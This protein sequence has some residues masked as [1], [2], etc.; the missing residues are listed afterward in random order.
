MNVRVSSFFYGLFVSLSLIILAF[1]S[2]IAVIWPTINYYD[3]LFAVIVFI[4]F[5]V[6]NILR[7]QVDDVIIIIGLLVLILLGVVGN[8]FS[9]INNNFFIMMVDALGII[10]IFISIIAIRK[11]NNNSKNFYIFKILV[12]FFSIYIY[13]ASIAYVIG[14]VSHVNSLFEGVRYGIPA[15]S[16]ICINPGEFGYTIMGMF[17]LLT[18]YEKNSSNKYVIP[19]LLALVLLITT[20]KGP[21]ILFVLIYIF[22]HLKKRTRVLL[23]L[24][25]IFS[26]VLISSY[27]LKNY[28]FNTGSARY[29]LNLTALKIGHDY[30]P[31]G[32]GLATFG[33]EMSRIH[34]SFVYYLYNLSDI[35]GLSPEYNLFINDN[36]WAMVV[37]ELGILAPIILIYIFYRVYVWISIKKKVTLSQKSAALT[38]FFVFLI[39]SIG[40]AYLT[41]ASGVFCYT[42]LGVFLSEDYSRQEV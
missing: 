41:S 25:F 21:Q 9:K 42:I 27:Q 17:C 5:L 11:L 30:F 2:N 16:F 14:I 22:F 12:Y 36:Y 18:F 20:T 15:Y 10:K 24:P 19:R 28:L 1:Q 7:F 32:T 4:L 8:Q 35:W 34:Y 37:G 40:S 29:L 33:S 39:G 26:G 3:E 31:F 6:S 13:I 23:I 38:M